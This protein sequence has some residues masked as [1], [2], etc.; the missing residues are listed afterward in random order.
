MFDPLNDFEI[1]VWLFVRGIINTN[2]NEFALLSVNM[3]F[4]P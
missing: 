4:H 3:A 1:H 2:C